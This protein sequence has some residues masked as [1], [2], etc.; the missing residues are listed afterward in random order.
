MLDTLEHDL[1]I[2]ETIVLTDDGEPTLNQAITPDVHTDFSFFVSH[3]SGVYYISLESWIRKVE[4]ELL[5]PQKEGS[6]FR[7]NRIL[8]ASTT[9]VKRYI[10]S[11]K[12]SPSE[13]VTACVIME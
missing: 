12:D 6:E 1:V 2:A 8:E 3:P 5:E 11:P 7:L 4:T 10:A 13:A 9:I